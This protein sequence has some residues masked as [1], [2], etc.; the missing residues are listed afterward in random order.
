ALMAL[1]A[2]LLLAHLW[3]LAVQAIALPTVGWDAWAA[4][5]A[6]ARA[7]TGAGELLPLADF[8][9][10]WASAPGTSRYAL[11]AHYPDALPRL[12]TWVAAMHG[13]WHEPAVHAAWPVLWLALLGVLFGYLRLA[14][15][16]PLFAAVVT[17]LVTSLPLLNTHVAL[18]GY[19]DLWLAAL[20]LVVFVHLQRAFAGRSWR[21]ALFA[22]LA[23]LLLPAVKLEGAI[24]MLCVLVGALV[25][26]V[27]ARWQ[28]RL[29]PVAAI[30]LL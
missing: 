7:W 9:A 13:G 12:L 5:L 3:T 14:G 10:W 17:Y 28:L 8:D 21:D 19:A 2:V 4:W 27:P 22:V 23:A 1:I 6:K 26:L 18:A 25:A 15:A 20:L 29:L 11:A 16:G 30:G 24:W